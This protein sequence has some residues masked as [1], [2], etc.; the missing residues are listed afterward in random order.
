MPCAAPETLDC[1]IQHKSH[2]L[3]TSVAGATILHLLIQHHARELAGST[4]DRWGHWCYFVVT[5]EFQILAQLLRDLDRADAALRTATVS[6]ATLH[7]SSGTG[8]TPD[9][10]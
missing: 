4:G 9:G 10:L 8:V 3:L 7:R 1:L 5:Q 2:L 6:V